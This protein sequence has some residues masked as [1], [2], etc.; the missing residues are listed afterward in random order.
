MSGGAGA[1]F[2]GMRPAK[3]AGLPMLKVW[4]R[5]ELSEAAA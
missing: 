1:P 5:D 3:D 4:H 2:T